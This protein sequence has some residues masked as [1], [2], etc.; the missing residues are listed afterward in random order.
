MFDDIL[1]LRS[2][3]IAIY[4][5]LGYKPIPSF[6]GLIFGSKYSKDIDKT[7]RF[8]IYKAILNK[9]NISLGQDIIRYF[10]EIL[11]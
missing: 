7:R 10:R 5:E 6:Y 2:R 11:K 4:K 3:T 8:S 9:N 1:S